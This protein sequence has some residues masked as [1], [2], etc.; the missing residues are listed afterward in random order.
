[1]DPNPF[2]FDSSNPRLVANCKRDD[3][4]LPAAGAIFLASVYLY[5]KKRFRIDQNF[6]NLLGF[7]AGSVP[8][9]YV[10]ANML[11]GDANVEAGLLNN[12][13]ERGF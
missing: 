3:R 6:L 4:I 2:T 1:M 12:Q 13:R 8:A 7:T 5:N 10:Y 11:F 9:S